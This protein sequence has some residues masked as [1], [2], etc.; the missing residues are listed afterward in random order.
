MVS[1]YLIYFVGD[2]P[3]HDLN[4]S[5]LVT[6]GQWNAFTYR[7]ADV[8]SQANPFSIDGVL[9]VEPWVGEAV[10]SATRG[11]TDVLPGSRHPVQKT[12]MLPRADGRTTGQTQFRTVGPGA[13]LHRVTAP[14]LLVIHPVGSETRSNWMATRGRVEIRLELADLENIALFE[15]GVSMGGS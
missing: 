5:A 2:I 7:R 8:E 10:R 14:L 4:Q 1:T 11:V 12:V 3:Q 9:G 13:E 15:G 6:G